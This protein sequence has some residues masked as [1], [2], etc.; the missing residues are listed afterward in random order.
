[1]PKE[2]W[3]ITGV[4]AL[5]MVCVILGGMAWQFHEDLGAV[6]NEL[7]EAS[8]RSDTNRVE[9]AELRSKLADAEAHAAEL[10]A[11]QEE[12]VAQQGNLEKEMRAAIES[13]E[14]TIS[15]LEG[16]LTVN[17]VDQVLF[18][19]GEAVL[20]PAGQDVLRKV[21][22]VLQSVPD[23]EIQVVGHTDNI[24][25]RAGNRFGFA[26]NWELSAARALA[27]VRFLQEQCGIDPK[28][29]GALG[30]GEFLP[31]GDN[32]TA[33]GRAKNRRIEVVVLPAALRKVLPALPALPASAHTVEQAVP[34]E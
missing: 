18:D 2:F 15:D 14:I 10:A 3:K 34:A 6:R 17:I 12:A 30:R 32:A 5:V 7:S 29:L 28:R 31:I 1:M 33:E 16:R 22:T 8:T 26:S 24:P 27:A 9:T 21:A 23:R 11:L 20:K 13:K 25:I 4:V 19:S